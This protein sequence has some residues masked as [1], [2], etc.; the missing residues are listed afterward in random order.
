MLFAATTDAAR[1]REFYE[2]V[3]GLKFVYDDQ[4]ALVFRVGGLTLRIQRVEHKP[5]IDYTVLGW[6]VADIDAEVRRLSKAGV[7][8]CHFDGLGQAKNG[9]WTSPSGAKVAWFKDPDGNTLSL[10]EQN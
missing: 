7:K 10:T 9:V 4:F 5:K 1:A 6:S 3:L 8:F 2:K